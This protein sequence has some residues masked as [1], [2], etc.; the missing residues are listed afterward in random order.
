MELVKIKGD[1]KSA[2]IEVKE[3]TFTLT[4][5][6]EEQLWEDKNVSEAASFREHPYLSEPKIWV[7]V[8][9]GNVKEALEKAIENLIETTKEFREK[10]KK[11]L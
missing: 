5:A 1:E 2:L 4:S 3:E 10:F 11:A 7:K 8:K 9:K 6:I